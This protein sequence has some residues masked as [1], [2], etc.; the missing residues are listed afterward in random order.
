MQ[1]SQQYQG[2]PEYKGKGCL[3]RQKIKVNGQMY[4]RRV[5]SGEGNYPDRLNIG[6][7]QPAHAVQS[8]LA[9]AANPIQMIQMTKAVSVGGVRHISHSS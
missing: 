9:V 8:S 4:W 5:F 2:T 7:N 1:K 6:A 3:N